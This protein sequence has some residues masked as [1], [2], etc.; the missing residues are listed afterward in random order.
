[1]DVYLTRE[2]VRSLRALALLSKPGPDGFLLG[3]CRAKRRLVDRVLPTRRGFFPSLEAFREADRRLGGTV[4]GFFSFGAGRERLKKI[5]APFACEKVFLD[6]SGFGTPRGGPQAFVI[7]YERRFGLRPV[8]CVL[9]K[10]TR[11]E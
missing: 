4:I 11:R 6:V 2:A 8:A 1:M 5:L 10:E 3:Y 9:E 7:E